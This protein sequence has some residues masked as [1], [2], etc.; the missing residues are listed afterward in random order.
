MDATQI[1]ITILACS[2]F[3]ELIR[4]A[5]TLLINKNSAEREMILGLAYDRIHYL[6]THYI[7]RGWISMEELEDLYKYLFIP[8]KKLGGNGTGEKLMQEV[9]KLP[10]QPPIPETNS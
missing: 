4:T 7:K 2:G 6:C 5:V 10:K 8:Y 9:D 3:W 1:A